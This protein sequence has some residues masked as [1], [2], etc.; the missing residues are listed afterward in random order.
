MFN[1]V[2]VGIP[3]TGNNVQSGEVRGVRRGRSYASERVVCGTVL[4]SVLAHSL[5]S[6]LAAPY[7]CNTSHRSRTI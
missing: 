7:Q 4:A 1:A 3:G 6:T 2:H 5:S